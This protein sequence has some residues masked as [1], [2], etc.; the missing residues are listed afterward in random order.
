MSKALL[1]VGGILNL[2]AGLA[3]LVLG[4]EIAQMPPAMAAPEVRAL[5][6]ALNLAVT[7]FIVFVAYASLVERRTLL[8]V[9]LGRSVMLV[10][11]MVYLARAIEEFLLF[12]FNA[13]LFAGS[14]VL[15]VLYLGLWLHAVHAARPAGKAATASA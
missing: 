3:H 6:L 11:G 4:R 1:T 9:R 13:A 2:L 12:R 8:E 10:A 15:A 5:T 7:L 14:L